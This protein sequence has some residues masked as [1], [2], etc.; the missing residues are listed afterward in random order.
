[1]EV[2]EIIEH[3]E[4]LKRCCLSDEIATTG[5]NRYIAGYP[6][7]QDGSGTVV[8]EYEDG[9][10]GIVWDSQDYTGHG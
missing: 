10:V 9:K 6:A 2:A 7:P 8:F 5:I 3:I 4:S 1:M